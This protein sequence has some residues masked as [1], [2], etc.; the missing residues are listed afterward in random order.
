MS[1]LAINV[2][3]CLPG[4]YQNE[5]WSM[6]ESDPLFSRKNEPTG[7]SGKRTITYRSVIGCQ[8]ASKVGTPPR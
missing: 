1:N 2:L 4:R 8:K 7:L 3:P 5:I 6:L